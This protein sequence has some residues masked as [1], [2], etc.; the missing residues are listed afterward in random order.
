MVEWVHKKV[1]RKKNKN[2]ITEKLQ[3]FFNLAENKNNNKKMLRTRNGIC[4]CFIR[5]TVCVGGNQHVTI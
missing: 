1:V 4:C 2:R 3:D 5:Y